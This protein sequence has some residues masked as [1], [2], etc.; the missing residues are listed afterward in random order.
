MAK[1]L[2][3]KARFKLSEL[4]VQAREEAGLTQIQVRKLLG[5]SQSELSKIENGQRKV[6]SLILEKFA[7]CYQKPLVFFRVLGLDSNIPEK[8]VFRE[9]PRE[10]IYNRD[11]RAGRSS[12]KY[13]IDLRRGKESFRKKL[14]R[15][16]GKVCMVTGTRVEPLIDAALLDP[17]VGNPLRIGNGLLLRTDIHTLFDLNLLGIEPGSLKIHV[18][19]DIKDTT[20]TQYHGQKLKGI[21]PGKTPDADLLAGRWK[22][23]SRS[24]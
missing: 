23:F 18:A 13:Y 24:D 10:S 19:P 6:E 1:T 15:T 17:S 20:Y 21:S 9:D 3:T 7:E 11:Q 14:F 22:I 4:L 2:Y 8:N 16:Y 5:I 12:S